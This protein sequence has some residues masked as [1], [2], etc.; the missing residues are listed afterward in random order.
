MEAGESIKEEATGEEEAE[1][2][3]IGVEAEAEGHNHECRQCIPISAN[4]HELLH[5]RNIRCIKGHVACLTIHCEKVARIQYCNSTQVR[6]G[7]HGS[8]VM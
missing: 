4:E 5:N 8:Y 3:V 7:Y 6:F 2:A 1:E